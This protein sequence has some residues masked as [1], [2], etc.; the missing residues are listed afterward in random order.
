MNELHFKHNIAGATTLWLI[1]FKQGLPEIEQREKT[2][3]P[4]EKP[5]LTVKPKIEFIIPSPFAKDTWI[6]ASDHSTEKAIDSLHHFQ[7]LCEELK[8]RCIEQMQ[9]LDEDPEKR[10][11]SEMKNLDEII[12]QFGEIMKFFKFFK[13]PPPKGPQDP[14]PPIN[15]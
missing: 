13:Q 10:S 14:E 4:L 9:L 2:S 12:R 3:P 8:T 1:Q 7:E 6:V 11:S 15:L 5:P